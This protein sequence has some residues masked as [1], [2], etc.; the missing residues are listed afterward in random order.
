MAKQPRVL[1]IGHNVLDSRTAFGKTITSF[2]KDW[3]S[4]NLA[5]LYFHSE[6]PTMDICSRYYRITDTDAL[7]SIIKRGNAGRSFDLTQ[8]EPERETSRVDDGVKTKVY[9]FGRKRTSYIYIA[10]NMV[11]RLSGWYSHKLK[12]WIK[13][14]NPDVIFFAT[15]DYAFANNIAYRISKDFDIPMVTY[16]CDDY[17]VNR[18]NPKSFLS[19]FVYR[20]L[21]KSVRR[22]VSRSSSL[23]T[24]C[25]KMTEA[26]KELFDKPIHTVYTGYSTS[27]DINVN[28]KGVVYLGNLGFSRYKSLVDIGN[29]LKTITDENGEKYHLDVYSA[30]NRE[31]ILS[32]LTEENGIVFHGSVGSDE[33][34][35]IIAGSRIVVH[36]ESFDPV[37]IY[38]VKYSVSTKIADLL[39]SGHCILAYGP[40]EVASVEYL[41]Q[42]S[43]ACVVDDRTMLKAALE[44]ILKDEARRL[45]IV[46]NAKKLAE[47]NHNS[48]N[49]PQRISD[50]ICSAVED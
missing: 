5:E 3:A 21:M 31:E 15:G 38:K 27:G 8:I 2:F 50:I 30:E 11:W 1:I 40:G 6:V 39:A 47:L 35:R 23:I 10:R 24:I 25:D 36:A 20:G 44:N 13:E 32:H 18:L 19:K 43:A 22:C 14:F 7:K 33:V 17:Y 37:N 26:Y 45:G 4:E 34:K 28:G 29:A 46:E 41:K 12:E 9:S 42:N 16:I 49:V 48:E